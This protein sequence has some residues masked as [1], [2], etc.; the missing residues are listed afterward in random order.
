VDWYYTKDGGRVGPVTEALLVER[1]GDGTVTSGTYV[2]SPAL[3]D[4]VRIGDTPS[5]MLPQAVTD[6]L[7]AAQHRARYA[8][9]R[10]VECGGLFPAR[11]TVV[12]GPLTVCWRCKPI[13]VR[14]LEQGTAFG[15]DPEF[16]GF[17][18]RAGAKLIDYALVAFAVYLVVLLTTWL[19][20]AMFDGETGMFLLS[21]FQGAFNFAISLGYATFFVGRFR[22]TPGKAA[23]GMEVIMGDGGK[24]SYVRA[25]LRAFGEMVSA[26]LFYIGYLMMLADD[27]NRTLHDRLCDT[28]VVMKLPAGHPRERDLVEQP[29]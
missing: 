5:G 26:M 23:L 16:A 21:L 15:L 12:I 25:L 4:W 24:V 18:R 10:C 6:A 13:H 9:I 11:D 2:W 17:W 19:A 3:P 1:I 22:A 7:S 29:A 8:A 28:R 20:P 14:R 27:E